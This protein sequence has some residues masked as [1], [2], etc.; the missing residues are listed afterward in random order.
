MSETIMAKRARFIPAGA[1]KIA[2]KVSGAEVYLYKAKQNGQPA[3]RAFAAKAIKPAF[4]F[5]YRNEADRD[6]KARDFLA[7]QR[8]RAEAAARDRA[9]RAKPHRLQV[10]HILRSS[11]GYE[12]TNIDFY[13]VTALIGA[14][15]VE[16][17]RIASLDATPVDAPAMTGRCVPH[18]DA[19]K[20]E[21]FRRRVN[22]ANGSVRIAS[23]AIATVWEGRPEHWTAYA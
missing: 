9:E 10:G 1:V 23:Y 16:L 4:S 22:G 18:V 12:Q 15:T 11:W 8:A 7:G 19:F 21:A 2:D 6:A 13:Q 14:H 3:V 17:R 20:G 5:F